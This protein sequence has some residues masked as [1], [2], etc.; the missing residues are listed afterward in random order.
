[1]TWIYRGRSWNFIARH[2]LNSK[3]FKHNSVRK[4]LLCLEIRFSSKQEHLLFF[5]RTWVLFPAFTKASCNSSS[6]GFEIF[7]LLRHW[8]THHTHSHRHIAIICLFT[9]YDWGVLSNVLIYWAPGS[10]WP[11]YPKDTELIRG[12]FAWALGFHVGMHWKLDIEETWNPTT[13]TGATNL[14]EI[15]TILVQ[16]LN[17]VFFLV[18]QKQE[19]LGL[20]TEMY[21]SKWFKKNRKSKIGRLQS[22][23]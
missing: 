17:K 3:A 4:S 10:W 21:V 15:M 22:L 19:K 8:H 9:Y 6:R 16:C 7:G 11:L 20:R 14:G 18:L 1:M 12:V 2:R 23:Q 5:Q 13:R